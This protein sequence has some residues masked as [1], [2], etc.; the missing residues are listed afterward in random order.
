MT[1][2]EAIRQAARCLEDAGVPD[3]LYDAAALLA[4]VTGRNA[5]LLRMDSDHPLTQEQQASY[6]ALL[7]RREARIP[8]QHLLGTAWFYGRAFSVSGDVLIPRPE[9]ELLVS[10]A[11]ALMPSVP[12]PLSVLDLC[13]GSGCIAISVRLEAGV[14]VSVSA[15]DISPAALSA[16]ERNARQLGA[17]DIRFLEGSLFDPLR[18]G[19]RFSMILS[20]PP[21]IPTGICGEL[22]P[23]VRHDPMLA[24]D[25]GK[26]GLD[27]VRG[28]L[29]GAPEHLLPGGVLLMEI[30]FDQAESV[31]HLISES[32]V[33]SPAA[34]LKD[35]AELDRVVE[36]RYAPRSRA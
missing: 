32:G 21:Y 4:H 18:D 3:P 22:Q 36:T 17:R 8:L 5:L 29:R 12:A 6:D 14:S 35:E 2:R 1:P 20:N 26:D 31:S 10:R 13:T 9:T 27:I 11:L 19:E 33:F 16:A 24:L 30:G 15:S 23:E 28:I 25:G 7:H 34:I